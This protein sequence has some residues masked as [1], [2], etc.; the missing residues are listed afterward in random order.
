MFGGK[1][2]TQSSA[3]QIGTAVSGGVTQN[4]TMNINVAG[5]TDRS[6]KRQIAREMSE[7]MQEE[8]ARAMG[9]TTTKSR[10]A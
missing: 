8:V 2:E 7:L 6:D 5:V 1:K 4:F 3:T 9:G 10:Y